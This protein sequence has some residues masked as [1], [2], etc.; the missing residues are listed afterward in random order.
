MTG[1]RLV[2]WLQ[3][4][5]NELRVSG[6]CWGVVSCFSTPG[7]RALGRPRA[8]DGHRPVVHSASSM[9]T[10]PGPT[11]NTSRRSWKSITSLRDLTPALS[12]G[13]GYGVEVVDGQRRRMIEPQAGEMGFGGIEGRDRVTKAEELY[14]LMGGGPGKGQA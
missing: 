6:Y 8:G 11:M 13:R 12:G 1:C 5:I 10:S 14:L 7:A 9:V 3:A 2:D 4:A